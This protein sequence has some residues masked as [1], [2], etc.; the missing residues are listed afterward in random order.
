M[1][2]YIFESFRLGFRNIEQDDLPTINQM[3][4]DPEVM[5]YFPSTLTED[6]SKNFIQKIKKHDEENGYSLWAVEIKETSEMI[7][8]MGLLKINFDSNIEGEIEIGWRL[9]KEYWHKGYAVEG[10]NRVLEYAS[11]KLGAEVIY[12]FTATVNKPSEQVMKRIGMEYISKFDHPNVADESIL[13]E[14][15]LYKKSF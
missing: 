12:S 4:S 2:N 11:E 1:K 13:K 14:H 15:L 8:I 7:G 6:E 9:L 5:A 3:N 10:A